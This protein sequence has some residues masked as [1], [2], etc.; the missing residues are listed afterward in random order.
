MLNSV[1]THTMYLQLRFEADGRAHHGRK[2]LLSQHMT[3]S[4]VVQTALLAVLTAEEHEARERFRYKGQ[5]IY[6]PHQSAE[7]LV[8]YPARLD[9]REPE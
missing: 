7:D 4:E 5:A 2:W 1:D 8:R 6:G 3:D 9:V